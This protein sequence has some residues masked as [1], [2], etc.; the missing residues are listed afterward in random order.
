[1][2]EQ[3]PQLAYTTP[4]EEVYYAYEFRIP[5]LLPIGVERVTVTPCE[6][7]PRLWRIVHR[8]ERATY[9][10]DSSMRVTRR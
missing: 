7:D 6:H 10:M 8:L 4:T 2:S 3:K 1:M 9:E 5:D